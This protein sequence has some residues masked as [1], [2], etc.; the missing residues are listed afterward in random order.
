MRR[1]ACR[2]RALLRGA[3]LL[4]LLPAAAVRAQAAPDTPLTRIDDLRALL[5]SV[6]R[7]RRPL[8]LFFTT[9]G[10]P[11]CREVRRSYLRPRADE[12]EAASGVIIREIEITSPRRLRDVDGQTLTEGALAT[13]YG[14][15]MVPHL[16][17][18]DARGERLVKPL[19]GLDSSGFYETFL[20]NAIAEAT[21]KLGR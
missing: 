8:L 11:Y 15:K 6:A 16:E 17:L 20:Q 18:V 5:A 3:A 7:E 1:G 21:A 14:V 9:P 2:R 19:I 10:C 12:G 13:R 4:A